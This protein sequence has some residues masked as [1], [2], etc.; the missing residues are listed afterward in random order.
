M[1]YAHLLLDVNQWLFAAQNV[2]GQLPELARSPL[3]PYARAEALGSELAG[4]S[5][6]RYAGNQ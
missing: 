3:R 2:V 4:A 5:S 1:R 6:G